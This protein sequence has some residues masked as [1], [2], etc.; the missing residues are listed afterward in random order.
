M[1]VATHV[2]AQAEILAI[3][4]YHIQTR[5]LLQLHAHPARLYKLCSAAT[6]TSFVGYQQGATSFVGYQRGT[7]L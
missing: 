5:V 3:P 2:N 1:P 4:V 6:G 7:K